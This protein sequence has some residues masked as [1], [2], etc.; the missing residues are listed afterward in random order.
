MWKEFIAELVTQNEIADVSFCSPATENELAAIMRA[1]HINA[2][3]SLRRLLCETNGVT[4]KEKRL[5]WSTDD[6]IKETLKAREC[7][8]WQ[9]PHVPI[10]QYLFFANA[11]GKDLFALECSNIDSEAKIFVWQS[12]QPF[13]VFMCESLQKWLQIWLSVDVSRYY[14]G[15]QHLQ[16]YAILISS[17]TEQLLSRKLTSQRQ[18][19]SWQKQIA[20][21]CGRCDGFQLYYRGELLVDGTI[22]DSKEIRQREE[23]ACPSCQTQF[24]LFDPNEH[25][26]DSVEGN[27]GALGLD[28]YST[29]LVNKLYRCE[30][31]CDRF[32]LI[33]TASYD[34]DFYE[35]IT[36]E[37]QKYLDES[38]GWFSVE[39]IC[40]NCH[41][42]QIAIDYE[43]A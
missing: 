32:I 34:I 26:Y 40:S 35:L 42:S 41:K 27:N 16:K 24:V 43:C 29:R 13:G 38:Y 3:H 11:N 19:Y 25:G 31:G 8:N 28:S 10:E 2:P 6:I 18:S 4:R 21:P 1:L 12:D 7:A 36:L 17:E 22:A 39:A 23:I 5:I 33:A 14:R 20:C 15:P 37:S 30:C 9:N